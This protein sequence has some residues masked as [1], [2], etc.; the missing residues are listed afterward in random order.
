MIISFSSPIRKD[1]DKKRAIKTK[2]IVKISESELIERLL[3]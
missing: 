1:F 2:T 3:Q